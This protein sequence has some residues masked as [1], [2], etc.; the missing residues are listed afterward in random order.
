MPRL[1]QFINAKRKAYT[2]KCFNR[3]GS[4]RQLLAFFDDKVYQNYALAS[5]HLAK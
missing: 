2:I 3:Y 4:R 5:C 1:F